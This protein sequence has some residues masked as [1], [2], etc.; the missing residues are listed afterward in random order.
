M[1]GN[2]YDCGNRFSC[3]FYADGTVACSHFERDQFASI[4]TPNDPPMRDFTEKCRAAYED[5]H[6]PWR[7][8]G[9]VNIVSAYRTRRA[10]RLARKGLALLQDA[11][12]SEHL[13]RPVR[14]RIMREIAS[15]RLDPKMLLAGDER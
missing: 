9:I 8:G 3:R 2:C 12:H 5:T 15:G 4:D 14:R 6:R 10:L 13:P 11:L 1:L 7:E